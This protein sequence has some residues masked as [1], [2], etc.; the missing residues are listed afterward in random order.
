MSFSLRDAAYDMAEL[1]KSLAA[2]AKMFPDAYHVEGR[3]WE[4]GYAWEGATDISVEKDGVYRGQWIGG[5]ENDR[6]NA[7]F[8]RVR[9]YAPEAW[10]TL[11]RLVKNSPEARAALMKL[12]EEA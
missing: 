8:V 12:L 5:T 11:H 10:W 1:A 9:R 4:R 2:A 3:C 6:R 7:V